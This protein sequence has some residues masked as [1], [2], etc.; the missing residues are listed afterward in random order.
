MPLLTDPAYHG[1]TAFFGDLHNHCNLSYGHGSLEDA[2]YNARL[3]LDFTSVTVHAVWHDIPRDDPELA[4]LIDYHD[5]GFTRAKANWQDYLTTINAHNYAGKFITLPSFEWHSIKY[6]D[7][8]VYYKIGDSASSVDAPILDAPDLPAL[9]Q[10]I[11]ELKTPALL[12]PHHIG[13]K[14]GSRGINWETFSDELSSVVEIFSFHGLS[15]S[16]E[17]AYPY[18]HS[19][20]PRHEHST[21]QYGWAQ[22]HIFGVIGSTDHHNA[23]PGSY[24]Y[25]RLGVWADSLSRESIWEAIKQR[26]TYALTGDR[27]ELAFALNNAPL[28][29]ITS[30]NPERYIEVDVLAG[31]SIDY[32]DVLHNNKIIHRESVLPKSADDSCYKV[33]MELGWAEQDNPYDWHVALQ[34]ENGN[35]HHVEPR[36]RG[37]GPTEATSEDM[38]FAYTRLDYTGGNSL[39]L[40]TRTSQN[41]SLHTASTEGLSLTIEGTAETRIIATINNEQYA[42]TLG[43]LLTG[44]RT[45]YTGGFVSP[46]ICFHRAIPRAEYHHHFAFTHI[47]QTSQRDWYYVRV[48]QRNNQWAWSSPIWVEGSSD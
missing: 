28:G 15:E 11:R 41:K 14:Q 37:N 21:A 32:I 40:H 12:I 36:L 27:I 33:Y 6:G 1:L 25:G 16:S 18:L 13:Y 35:L 7:Y 3:Q 47:N 5:E 38:D 20:G 48:R 8:C 26:R 42:L 23:F 22:G 30:A 17:G 31:D 24:G 34:V 19:M 44:T 45:F 4:Y 43:D 46:A 9:R 39:Q 2:L 29:A 10:M